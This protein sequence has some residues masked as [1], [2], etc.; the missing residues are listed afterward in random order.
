MQ[1]K[2]VMA[3]PQNKSKHNTGISSIS[4]KTNESLTYQYLPLQACMGEVSSGATFGGPQ[5]IGQHA[6]MLT[7]KFSSEITYS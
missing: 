7:Q 4:I 3:E 6:T 5:S 2:Q 1:L